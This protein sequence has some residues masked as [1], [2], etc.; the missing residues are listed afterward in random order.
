MKPNRDTAYLTIATSIIAA[1]IIILMQPMQNLFF[2]LPDN[3]RHLISFLPLLCFVWLIVFVI[4]ILKYTNEKPFII[5][6]FIIYLIFCSLHGGISITMTFLHVS[7]QSLIMFYQVTAVIK[8]LVIIGLIV[9]AFALRPAQ[10]RLPLRFFALG[11]LFIMLFYIV[12]PPLLILTG[13][14]N[15]RDYIRYSG[16]VNLII[17][18]AGV[19]IAVTVLNVIG[20]QQFE[21]RFQDIDKQYLPDDKTGM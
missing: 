17:P 9:A 20:K 21:Q 15:Y 6:T 8:L 2:K 10:F 16:L 11:E 1:L 5:N 19:Y 12:I 13:V 3:F 18:A 14:S 4:S 7:A